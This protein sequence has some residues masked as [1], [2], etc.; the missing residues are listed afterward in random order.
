VKLTKYNFS[1]KNHAY[2]RTRGKRL[3]YIY[4][5]H[6]FAVHLTKEHVAFI[7]IGFGSWP[8][9]ERRPR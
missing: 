7:S 9:L 5:S 8:I 1:F 2:R 6:R 4:L 3:R